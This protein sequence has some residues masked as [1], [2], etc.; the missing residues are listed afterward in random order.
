MGSPL[1]TL[2]FGLGGGGS[3]LT[4]TPANTAPAPDSA[5]S[6]CAGLEHKQAIAVPCRS[7]A[8][9][10]KWRATRV[11]GRSRRIRPGELD[12]VDFMSPH[13]HWACSVPNPCTLDSARRFL[14]RGRPGTPGRTLSWSQ[15][16]NRYVRLMARDSLEPPDSLGRGHQS[17]PILA[18]RAIESHC[19]IFQRIPGACLLRSGLSTTSLEGGNASRQVVTRVNPHVAS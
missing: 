11:K 7:P 12:F 17:R 1:Q 14:A 3:R 13:I 10:T 4:T 18:R 8:N 5:S 16:G 2:S 15:N 19:V 6:E 9:P